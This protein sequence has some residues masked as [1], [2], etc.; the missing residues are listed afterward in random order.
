MDPKSLNKKYEM[1]K[2]VVVFN[3]VDGLLFPTHC[4]M[5]VSMHQYL[6]KVMTNAMCRLAPQASGYIPC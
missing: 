2:F 1:D 3:R 6:R 5:Q 4:I